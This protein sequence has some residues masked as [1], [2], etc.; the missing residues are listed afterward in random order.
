MTTHERE[1][2]HLIPLIPLVVA[3]INGMFGRFFPRMLCAG[4]AVTAILTS[5]YWAVRAVVDLANLD[6]GHNML[7]Q[8]LWTWIQTGS[9]RVDLGL[10]VDPL[11]GLML[12]IITGIG[13]L[14]HIY[15]VGYMDHEEDW[16]RF[17]CALNLFVSFMLV[18]VMA[19]SLPVM[20]IGWE[21]VGVCSYL[22]IG[23]YYKE[24]EKA[25]A[26]KKAFIVNRVG[27]VSF[28]LGML[29]LGLTMAK[30]TG[31]ASL[32]FM[33]INAAADALAREKL[34]VAWTGADAHGGILVVTVV[35][36]LLFG[37]AT[38][39]SAQIPL[40][41][42]LPDAM[43]G[44]TPVS[45][46]IHAA[47]MVT[48]G[49]F[50]ICRLSPLFVHAPEALG[51]IAWV[52]ALTALFAALIAVT[53]RD[54]K[55]VLAY[56]TVS[57]L[58]YMFLALGVGA[59]STAMFHLTTHA[60]FKALMF[61]GAGSVIHSLHGEQD[62]FKMGNL[63]RKI[64]VTYWTFLAGLL[65][66]MGIFPFAGFFSKDEI[67]WKTWSSEHGSPILY[68]IGLFTAVLTAFYM[69]RMFTLVFLA[70]SN[71][72]KHHKKKIHESPLSM[73]FALGVLAFLSVFGGLMNVPHALFG[74]EWLDAT[75]QPSLAVQHAAHHAGSVWTERLFMVISVLAAAISG[76]VARSMYIDPERRR[77]LEEAGRTSV[78]S[79]L[80]NKFYVDE[81]F[82]AV[83]VKPILAFS[84]F[85]K[86]LF[87]ALLIDKVFV[88][89]PGFVARELAGLLR[90]FQSGDVQRYL[91]MLTLGAISVLVYVIR[92][93]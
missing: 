84:K 53:Q 72:D 76:L 45:A 64:P 27:D 16:H 9:F 36:L 93:P 90:E 92:V 56:S 65:A 7:R 42:W 32:D 88:H 62:I 66:I 2:L 10:M 17:F 55:K 13:S 18:L 54:I 31:E 77:F 69:T 39:K 41:V 57:Q 5:F 30:V 20:F 29:L 1:Y 63:R 8:E 91:L 78:H 35:C 47:T 3:A 12:M 33:K 50:M 85:L 73:L 44:P 14:I 58:G 43:A 37:G 71:V 79:L 74:H 49:I 25:S 34:A 24:E 61:L 59:F 81:I 28:M 86:D 40:Y 52:G 70:P 75:L 22:L 46:L 83:I 19:T 89:G 6:G 80:L 87:D 26:G 21:G 67:L 4:G 23:F 82:D 15:S 38:G 51:V 11:T 68:L 48:S 60:F